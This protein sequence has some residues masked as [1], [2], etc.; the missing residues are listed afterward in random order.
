VPLICSEPLFHTVIALLY[1]S[2]TIKLIQRRE[3]LKLKLT[4]ATPL[5]SPLRLTV[6]ISIISG[7][8][9]SECRLYSLILFSSLLSLLQGCRPQEIFVSSAEPLRK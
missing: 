5:L 4:F 6:V 8:L 3:S 1:Y 7:L 9:L 2:T